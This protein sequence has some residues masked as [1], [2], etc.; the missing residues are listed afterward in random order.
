MIIRGTG[1]GWEV[2]ECRGV[3]M[4]VRRGCYIRGEIPLPRDRD[5]ALRASGPTG[6]DPRSVRVIRDV[7]AS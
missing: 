2:A 4:T 5:S 6:S 3:R 7:Y 1:T